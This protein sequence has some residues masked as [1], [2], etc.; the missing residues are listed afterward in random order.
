[1]IKQQFGRLLISREIT[2]LGVLLNEI[3]HYLVKRSKV[4]KKFI[5]LTLMGK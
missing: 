1:K 2:G 5:R 4:V 3:L